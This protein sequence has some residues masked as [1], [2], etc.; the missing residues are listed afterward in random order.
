MRSVL[1]ATVVL[2]TVTIVAY[3]LGMLGSAVP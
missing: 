3:A 2:M 1:R